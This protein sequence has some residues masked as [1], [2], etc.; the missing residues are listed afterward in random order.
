M[1]IAIIADIPWP[2]G[3]AGSVRVRRWAEELSRAG[4]EVTV[5]PV[6]NFGLEDAKDIDQE[7]QTATTA[8]L[9]S[10]FGVF[11]SS[12]WSCLTRITDAL[13][14]AVIDHSRKTKIELG[15]MGRSGKIFYYNQLS[16]SVGVFHVENIFRKI[17]G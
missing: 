2:T 11:G 16:L 7:F 14:H 10:N 8:R 4:C 9:K 6:G 3:A 13:A 1:R 5:I 15:S 12:G 17:L